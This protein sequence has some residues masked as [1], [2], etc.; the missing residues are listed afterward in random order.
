M[1]VEAR[2]NTE[3]SSLRPDTPITAK[4]EASDDSSKQSLLPLIQTALEMRRRAYAPYSAFAVGAAI[5]TAD[6][7]IFGGC[8]I[9]NAAYGPTM[10]AERTAIFKAVSEGHRVFRRIVIA[11]GP[12]G[13]E[14]QS[15]CPPCGSCRQVLAEFCDPDTFEIILTK[16]DGETE[17]HTL[18][19]LLPLGF[20]KDALI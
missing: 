4:P 9:E 3:N 8:N 5:E 1:N 6:G 12:A 18:K 16:A 2:S 19:E 10:C 20:T 17:T 13:Q 7:K 14:P 11:G 15:L